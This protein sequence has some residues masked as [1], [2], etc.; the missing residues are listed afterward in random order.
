MASVRKPQATRKTRPATTPE[1]REQQMIALAVDRAEQQL[2]DGSASAQ[3]ITHYL[4]LATSREKLEQEK[5]RN[6]NR[7]LVGQAEALASAQR[8]EEAYEK[9]LDAMRAYSGTPQ[10]REDYED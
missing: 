6:Q 8:M 3:V 1:G 5:I 9:A 2:R 10:G 7:L 4:K